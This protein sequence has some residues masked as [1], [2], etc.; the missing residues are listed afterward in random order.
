MKESASAEM[1]EELNALIINGNENSESQREANSP[2]GNESQG[3]EVDRE[4]NA[5]IENEHQD[6]ALA[7]DIT[8]M[9][10]SSE[11]PLSSKCCIYR[12]P[13]DLRKL[14]VEAYTPQ[15]LYQ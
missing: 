11:P 5:S 9:L 4:A 1:Q 12:V 8:K 6:R 10:E 3:R 2:S 7:N 13:H 14:N 15:R